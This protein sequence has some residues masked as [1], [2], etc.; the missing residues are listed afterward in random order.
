MKK[1]TGNTFIDYRRC[2]GIPPSFTAMINGGHTLDTASGIQILSSIVQV[3][4][5]CP[6][7]LARPA[8]DHV[9]P[10]SPDPVHGNP[11]YPE[12]SHGLHVSSPCPYVFSL[13]HLVQTLSSC[14]LQVQHT[15][16]HRSPEMEFWRGLLLACGDSCHLGV[17]AWSLLSVAKQHSQ[18]ICPFFLAHLV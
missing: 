5:P 9:R 12:R 18:N 2:N 8:P 7:S 17:R 10:F 14:T 13:I 11:L 4:S 15:S 6:S 3:S 1:D 16:G